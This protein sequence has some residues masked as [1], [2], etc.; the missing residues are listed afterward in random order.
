MHFKQKITML[1]LAVT[2]TPIFALTQ[3]KTLAV[4]VV[5]KGPK[6]IKVKTKGSGGWSEK[7]L[8]FD[9]KTKGV[10]NAKEGSKVTIKYLEKDGQ[11]KLLKSIHAEH[12]KVYSSE[13]PLRQGI[14]LCVV[15]QHETTGSSSCVP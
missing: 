7:T 1:F 13:E 2:L 4:R 5:S 3:E 10:E 11:L 15:R 9:S 14:S 12:G 6:E 8:S